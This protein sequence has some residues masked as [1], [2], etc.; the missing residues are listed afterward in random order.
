MLL[1]VSIFARHPVFLP[2]LPGRLAIPCE[3]PRQPQLTRALHPDSQIVE[4]RQLPAAGVDAF[5]DHDSLRRHLAHS[6]HLVGSPVVAP[7]ARGLPAT[8]RLEHLLAKP[9]PVEVTPDGLLRR[10]PARP[11]PGRQE[12]VIDFYDRRGHMGRSQPR[13]EVIGKTALS[14]AAGT[15]DRHEEDPPR[16][17]QGPQPNRKLPS[18]HML[19]LLGIALICQAAH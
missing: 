14:R 18:P 3:A 1:K 12:E 9:L 17:V 8:K 13:P 11:S 6:S 2:P 16:G 15:I 5:Y 4:A 7:V 19:L 10:G